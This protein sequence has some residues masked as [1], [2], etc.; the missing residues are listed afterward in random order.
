MIAKENPEILLDSVRENQIIIRSSDDTLMNRYVGQL[1]SNE[2]IVTGIIKE[3]NSL[4]T[5][6]MQLTGD[7][8][9]YAN[10]SNN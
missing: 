4:E 9:N 2:V 10:Q 1:I 3:E 7:N 5:L 6:F 8:V